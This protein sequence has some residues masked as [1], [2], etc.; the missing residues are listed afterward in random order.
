M[1]TTRTRN[2]GTP[3][4]Q[5]IVDAETSATLPGYTPPGG[6]DP[7][8]DATDD[9]ELALVTLDQ[10][11]GTEEASWAD[12]VHALLALQPQ[13]EDELLQQAENLRI[14]AENGYRSKVHIDLVVAEMAVYIE[15]HERWRYLPGCASAAD[16]WAN[17][18][19][20]YGDIRTLIDFRRTALGVLGRVG[21]KVEEH[22]EELT[23]AK[24]KLLTQECR[25]IQ[26]QAK[27][28]SKL[29]TKPEVQETLQQ[30]ASSVFAMS[31][32]D[33]ARMKAEQAGEPE[34]VPVYH[35]GQLRTRNGELGIE[36]TYFLSLEKAH[37]KLEKRAY[38]VFNLNGEPRDLGELLAII[39]QGEA[40][41]YAGETDTSVT[42]RLTSAAAPAALDALDELGDF[43]TVDDGLVITSAGAVPELGDDDLL[44]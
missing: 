40:A 35:E 4:E 9:T 34:R 24:M 22:L 44:G 16:F 27:S 25:S 11:A 17:T 13:S 37:S 30:F 15:E 10:A 28:D 7:A 39:E 20:N 12:V 2:T 5:P 18:H 26:R 1:S 29:L 41:L 14:M 23:P 8:T 31:D 6:L 21:V 42:A 3:N 32:G 43:S 33:L 36:F 19:W 38:D